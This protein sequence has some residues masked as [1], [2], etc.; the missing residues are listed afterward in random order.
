MNYH[1]NLDKMAKIQETEKSK[2]WQARKEMTTFIHCWLERNNAVT[3]ERVCV[4][5]KLPY[6]PAIPL[7]GINSKHMN[8]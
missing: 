7:Q 3:I 8:F 5:S 1:L 6:D 4:F 2:C